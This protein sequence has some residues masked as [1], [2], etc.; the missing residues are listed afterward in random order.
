[1]QILHLRGKVVA[2]PECDKVH[3]TYLWV[4]LHFFGFLSIDRS[5]TGMFSQMTYLLIYCPTVT[6][7]ISMMGVMESIF[8]NVNE[9]DDTSLNDFVSNYDEMMMIVH[10]LESL[11][12]TDIYKSL[13]D[14]ATT[15]LCTCDIVSCVMFSC[16]QEEDVHK[17]SHIE[18]NYTPYAS[19]DSIGFFVSLACACCQLRVFV[20]TI[21][22]KGRTI[23]TN[24]NGCDLLRGAQFKD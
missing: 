2:N 22:V 10:A 1:M 24:P 15:F 5:Q 6:R 11:S 7:S 20:G 19:C 3:W 8:K 14:G 21:K 9:K 13:L 23:T 17:F 16:Q 12:P 4:E 18:K